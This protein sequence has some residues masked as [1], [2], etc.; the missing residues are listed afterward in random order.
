MKKKITDLWS[1]QIADHNIIQVLLASWLID[2]IIGPTGE[3]GKL[4]VFSLI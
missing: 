2:S 3:F 1:T 4:V